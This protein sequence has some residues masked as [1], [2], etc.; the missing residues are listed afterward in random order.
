MALQLASQRRCSP[1]FE[2]GEQ[3][4][5]MNVKLLDDTLAY[6]EAHPEEHDQSTWVCDTTMCFAGHAL[7]LSGVKVEVDPDRHILLDG[8]RAGMESSAR[9]ALGLTYGEAERLFFARDLWSVR[10][11]VELIKSGAFRYGD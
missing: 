11:A 10:E 3:M 4:P 8:K 1:L 7:A 6:I 2:K 5:E 9:E